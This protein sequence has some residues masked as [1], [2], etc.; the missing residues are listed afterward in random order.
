MKVLCAILH[1]LLRENGSIHYVLFPQDLRFGFVANHIASQC[2]HK[3]LSILA[4]QWGIAVIWPNSIIRNQLS[5]SFQLR[6]S[7]LLKLGA[8]IEPL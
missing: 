7:V 1:E 3:G 4:T 2:R 8:S 5:L 6:A